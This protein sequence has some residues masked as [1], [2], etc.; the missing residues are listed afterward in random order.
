MNCQT[1]SQNPRTYKA[2]TTIQVSKVFQCVEAGAIN[3]DLRRDCTLL[4]EGVDTTPQS[5]SG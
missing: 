1:F 2:T 5:S 3:A 4:M